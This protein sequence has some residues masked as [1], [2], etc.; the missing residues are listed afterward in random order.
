MKTIREIF[1]TKIK[2]LSE[3]KTKDGQTMSILA[4]WIV[5]DK[6]NKNGRLY[7]ISLLQREVA[8]FQDRV[9][10][11]S[12]I[13]S[14]DH[15]VGAFTTLADAS[16]IVRK[17]EV[18]KNGKGWMEAEILS[19]SKGK[20][21]IEIIKAGGQLGISARGAGSVSSNGTVESDYKL[22]GIDFCTSPSEPTAT[23]DK[24]NVFESVEFE[25][26]NLDDEEL[27]KSIDELERESYLSACE[28]GFKG[29]QKEW[30][31]NCGSL[32]EMMGIPEEKEEKTNVQKLTEQ[33][34]S[35][36]TRGYYLEAQRGGFM[37]SFDEWKEKFPKLV[38]MAS[39]P[40]K[41]AEKKEVKQP[42]NARI[43]LKEARLSGFTGTAEE[44][45]EQHPD[46]ELVM[47]IPPQEKLVA[48][49]ILTE[50]ALKQ[51]AGRIFAKLS[52]ENPNSQI[53]LESVIR[54]LEKE[55]IVKSDKRLRKRAIYIVNASIAGSGASPSQKMLEKMVSEEIENLKEKRKEMRE[56]NWQAY[57]HL[58]D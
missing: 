34:I 18:D 24:S 40:I 16:H 20:N 29:N 49:K 31:Q 56:R 42:F 23:F 26:E 8:S 44:F 53:T 5:A 19:T 9:K 14:A 27:M 10:R 55:E 47:L 32:R 7:P 12:A 11:G 15:P 25:E 41:I 17:L 1:E 2:I 57:K 54:M 51:E 37:G 43:S 35:E 21:V 50:E 45:K 4:P 58:L 30:L 48:E 52:Q 13:G 3:K 38:E 36:R 6:K 46:I 39:E 33:Q 22:L 28:S